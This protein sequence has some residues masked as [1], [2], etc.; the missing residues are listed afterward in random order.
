VGCHVLDY[1]LTRNGPYIQSAI[2]LCIDLKLFGFAEMIDP[3]ALLAKIEGQIN[4]AKQDKET[5]GA[6]VSQVEKFVHALEQEEW[7]DEFEKV[8]AL[9][10]KQGSL[11]SCRFMHA[12]E[13]YSKATGIGYASTV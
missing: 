6:V 11:N 8:S 10:F 5:R 12:L 9:G 3:S 4:Q 7:L 2:I 13:E 1:S